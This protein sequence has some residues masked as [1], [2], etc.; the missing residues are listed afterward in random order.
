M[1]TSSTTNSNFVAN[2]LRATNQILQG[3]YQLEVRKATDFGTPLIRSFDTNDRLSQGITLLAQPGSHIFD[4]QTF[5]IGDGINTVVF[6]YEDVTANNGIK[7]GHQA[8]PFNPSSPDYVVA[9][10]VRDAIN[11]SEVQAVLPEV[12][13][14]L[15]DGTIVG[16]GNPTISTSARVNLFGPAHLSIHGFNVTETNDMLGE[17][18]PTNIVGQN[19]PSFLGSGFIGD[20][21]GFPLKTGLDVDLFHLQLERGEV[22][23]LDVDADE[24]GSELDSA[25]RVFNSNGVELAFSDDDQAPGEFVRLDPFLEFV[26]QTTGDY[27]VGVSAF[28]NSLYDPNVEASGNNGQTGFYQIEITFGAASRADFLLFDDT[29]DS[30]QARDQGQVLI[31]SNRISNSESFGI[32]VDAGPRDGGTNSD[33]ELNSTPH[34][35]PVRNLFELNTDNLATSAVIEN[36]VLFGNQVGAIRFSG[37]TRPTGEQVGSVPFGRIVNNTLYGVGGSLAPT[38]S[39]DVGILIDEFAAPTILNNIVA[40]FDIGIQVVQDGVSENQTIVGGQLYQGNATSNI[41]GVSSQDFG[42]ALDNPDPT[43]LPNGPNCVT[44][45]HDPNALF[46]N[47]FAENFYLLPCS[48]AIDSSVGSLL[49]RSSFVRV[50]D[51]LGI[52]PS[53]ILAPDND[54]TGQLRADDP[55]VETPN[56]FGDDVFIDRGGID[57]ADF[58]GPTANLV[59]PTD[60]DADGIDLR[61]DA[62][63]VVQLGAGVISSNFEIRLVD[64]V[65][66]ADPTDGIGI[67]DTTVLS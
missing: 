62:L 24:I 48:R 52:G 11:G 2:P 60:N 26:A 47:P 50:K 25:L 64:G 37:E 38:G 3:P 5:V 34:M 32:V 6:E 65:E 67:D 1:A 4:G 19:S 66:P 28:N 43:A 42:I 21:P 35:G 56:G 40:N 36:N 20:N 16:N 10:T 29:G 12:S 30:N 17:A 54:V 55:N 13:A 15:G 27:F 53:P 22:I 8:I 63:S 45:L 18:T 41:T 23:R 61:A 31:H 14:V 51:P 39:G 7:S 59:N 44:D 58:A 46:V 57:R 33:G 9:R 49:D